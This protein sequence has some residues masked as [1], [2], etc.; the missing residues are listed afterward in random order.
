VERPPGVEPVPALASRRLFL[1]GLV[2]IGVVAAVAPRALLADG[3]GERVLSFFHTHT[4]ERITVPYFADGSYLPGGLA[5]LDSFLRDHRTG[6]EHP[7]DPALYDLLNDVR[8]A[9]NARSPFQVISGYRSPQTNEMLRGH[10]R[11]VAGGS[12]H[13]KGRAIDV[14]LSD[15][16][17]VVLR[18][19]GLELARGGV[20]YYG[21][22]DFVHLDTGR[23]RRW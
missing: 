8:L 22:S 16:K 10:G 14:R 5:R 2:G 4:H 23:V 11:G 13:L 15:V 9:T 19:A 21:A 20:G 17:T 6:G 3:K 18:D 1:K 7:I 12:L